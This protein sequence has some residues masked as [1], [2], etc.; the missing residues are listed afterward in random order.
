M[1]ASPPNRLLAVLLM[2]TWS[3]GHWCCCQARAAAA[4]QASAG[5]AHSCCAGRDETVHTTPQR[6]AP[7][8]GTS[9][10]GDT[11]DDDSCGC[12]HASLDAV[13]PAVTAA[14]DGGTSGGVD[15][16]VALPPVITAVQ[17][18]AISPGTTCRGSPPP[19]RAQTLLSLH[20][21]L[22]T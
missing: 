12:L 14:P 20:C 22:T 13:P 11:P 8:H 16:L 17:T 19:L 18:L 4:P 15:M 1:I 2:A 7:C 9:G 21:Q 6:P 10:C 3:P 5:Q